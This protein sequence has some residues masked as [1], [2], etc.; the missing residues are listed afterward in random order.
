MSSKYPYINQ[1]ASN[2]VDNVLKCISAPYNAHTS[3]DFQPWIKIDL[4]AIYDVNKITIYNRQDCCGDRLHDVQVNI[5][6]NGTEASCGFYK[7]PADIGDQISV[8]CVSSAA[9][10]YVL[11]KILSQP[12]IVEYLTVCEVQ[13]FVDV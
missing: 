13:I 3:L 5:I 7:G 11:M 6:N 10:R 2:A 4:Q 1:T 9:G 12:G 8:Y